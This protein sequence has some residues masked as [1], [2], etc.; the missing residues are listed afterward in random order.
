MALYRWIPDIKTP[1]EAAFVGW[2]GPM[3]VGAIF[4]A[5]LARLHLPE[6]IDYPSDDQVDILAGAIQPI[7]AFLVLTSV[8]CR[9]FLVGTQ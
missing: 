6:E 2:F 3:G 5:T 9:E 7:V 1:R 8:L 4:I